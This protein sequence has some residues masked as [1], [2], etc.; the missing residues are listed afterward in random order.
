[1]KYPHRAE[2]STRPEVSLV[3][4]CLAPLLGNSLDNETWPQK[5]YPMTVSKGCCKKIPNSFD[6][7]V[8]NRI[9]R[10]SISPLVDLGWFCTADVETPM[11]ELLQETTAFGHLTKEKVFQK[12]AIIPLMFGHLSGGLAQLCIRHILNLVLFNQRDGGKN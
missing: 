1:M 3:P 12:L 4:A 7:S 2:S 10:K 6:V 5:L 8:F 9:I 11:K